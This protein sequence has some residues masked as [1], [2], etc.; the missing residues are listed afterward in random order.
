M[1]L[2][3]HACCT[4]VQGSTQ[5]ETD[6]AVRDCWWPPRTSQTIC[7]WP[8]GI[9]MMIITRI[10]Q[11]GSGSITNIFQ[12]PCVL[13]D[14]GVLWQNCQ[15]RL[16]AASARIITSFQVASETIAYRCRAERAARVNGASAALAWAKACMHGH[17]PPSLCIRVGSC[18]LLSLT[19]HTQVYTSVGASGPI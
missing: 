4:C 10:C 18:G 11:V 15:Q 3:T 8:L 1:F 16:R 14:A 19:H 12:V 17:T 6:V 7:R 9:L 13:V 5:H 2:C